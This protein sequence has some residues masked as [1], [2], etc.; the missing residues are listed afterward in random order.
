MSVQASTRPSTGRPALAPLQ[1]CFALIRDNPRPY[2]AINLLFFGLVFL[3]FVVS[4]LDPRLQEALQ[5]ALGAGLNHGLLA[6]VASLY[7]SGNV[8]LAAL[9][10]FLVNSVIGAFAST[11]CR[12][13]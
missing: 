3:G 1:P 13:S 10:T 8:P 5:A 9:A 4:A 11:L 2:L 6:W 12:H 7:R